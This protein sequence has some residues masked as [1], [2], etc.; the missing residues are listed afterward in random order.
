VQRFLWLGKHGLPK[1]RIVKIAYKLIPKGNKVEFEIKEGK[2]IDFDPEIGTVSRAKVVCPCCGATLSDKEVRKQFQEGKSG[3]RMVAVVL[4]HPKRN[5]KTYRLA[6]EKIW[7]FL[8]SI[9]F[10]YADC[11]SRIF[12]NKCYAEQKPCRHDRAK[13]ESWYKAYIDSLYLTGGT[14][15]YFLFSGTPSANRTYT[16]PDKSGTIAMTSDVSTAAPAVNAVTGAAADTTIAFTAYQG[17]FTSTLTNK[18]MFTFQGLGAF[19]DVSVVKIEQKTGQCN[20]R[21]G[22]GSCFC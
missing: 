20:G 15:Y 8:V 1:K 14:G 10:G 7:R 2:Q 16:L 22:F 3:Q 12:S 21:Y 9:V 19:G 17:T 5:G 4:N 11:D 6:T 13:W 18:D